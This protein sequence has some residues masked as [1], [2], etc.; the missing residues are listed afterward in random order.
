MG[1]GACRD[2]ELVLVDA[3][4]QYSHYPSDIT[5]TWPVSGMFTGPQRDLYQAVLNVQKYAITLAVPGNTINDIDNLVH[6]AFIPE[7]AQLGERFTVNR[8]VRSPHPTLEQ[9]Y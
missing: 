3:A 4:G 6:E 9:F 2:G 8:R 5:R 7:L 1:Y